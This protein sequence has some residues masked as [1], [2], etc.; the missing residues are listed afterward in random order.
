LIR[1][2][3]AGSVWWRI[4]SEAVSPTAFRDTG[5][6]DK[7]ADTGRLGEEG[8]FDCQAGEYGYLYLGQTKASTI[9]EAF[10]RKPTVTNPAARFMRRARLRGRV[11]SRIEFAVDV[12]V[13]DLCGARGLARIGQ[14][15]WL[16]ACDE[17]D[18]PITQAWATALRRWSPAPAAT[19]LVWMSKRDNVHESTVLF[20]DHVNAADLVG[21]VYRPLA[22]GL[23]LTLV[24]KVLAG[25]GVAIT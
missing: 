4:H 6:I 3:P 7:R 8:R 11:L 17:P 21:R 18:Y 10:L 20:N 24:E 12:A 14:D 2:L 16:T 19:G 15:A 23:G 13:I 1:I 5:A 25:F 22:D 9:A